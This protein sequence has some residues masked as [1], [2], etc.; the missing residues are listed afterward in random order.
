MLSGGALPS[1]LRTI[2][3]GV[4]T[5]VSDSIKILRKYQP[6]GPL[7]V[8]EFW[9]G[10]YVCFFPFL[11]QHSKKLFM[12]NILFFFCVGLTFGANL[13]KPFLL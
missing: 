7:F 5:N 13:I 6:T 4:G 2:N 8:T 1:L 12:I 10:W 11:L 3:F 9:D